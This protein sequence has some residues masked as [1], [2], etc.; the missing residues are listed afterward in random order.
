MK[1][2]TKKKPACKDCIQFFTNDYCNL[3]RRHVKPTGKCPKFCRLAAT[4]EC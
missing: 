4:I 3:K 1:T 2:K